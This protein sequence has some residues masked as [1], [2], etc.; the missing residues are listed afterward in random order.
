MYMYNA[1][2][3]TPGG[4]VAI[5]HKDFPNGHR[6]LEVGGPESHRFLKPGGHRL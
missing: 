5:G 6:V 3:E 4:P 1:G 2:L